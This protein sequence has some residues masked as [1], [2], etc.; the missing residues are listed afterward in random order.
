[1]LEPAEVAEAAAEVDLQANVAD[2]AVAVSNAEAE[3]EAEAEAPA[4]RE[5]TPLA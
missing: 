2:N 5:E 4:P 1:M 3:V